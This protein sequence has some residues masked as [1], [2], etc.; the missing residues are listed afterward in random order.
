[1]KEKTKKT[2]KIPE[3]PHK[4][5][6]RAEGNAGMFVSFAGTFAVKRWIEGNFT[7]KRF[8]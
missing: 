4:S 5:A 8:L 6:M 1:M 2:K 3:F 7:K